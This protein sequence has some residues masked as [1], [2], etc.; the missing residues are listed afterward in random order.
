L[1]TIREEPKVNGLPARAVTDIGRSRA[2]PALVSVADFSLW[3]RSKEVLRGIDLEIPP[4][5]FV[6]VIG[7]SGSGKSTLLNAIAGFIVPTSA[8]VTISG[9]IKVGDSPP[10]AHARRCGVVFQEYA[11][12]PWRTARRNVEFSLEALDVPAAER[13]S[14]SLQYLRQVGLGA[15]ADLYPHQLSGGMKQRVA[16]ARALAY[17]PSVLLMDEPLGALDALTREKLM[18]LIDRVWR[19]TQTTVVY[20]THNVSEAVFL[21]DRVL[22]LKAQPGEVVLDLAIDLPRP[23]DPLSSGAVELERRLRDAI[24]ESDTDEESD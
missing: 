10:A 13:T 19:Q 21:A 23:R 1:A 3:F 14:R 7:P 15:A 6:A 20:I 5:Q 16:I 12:F 17:E 22:V 11:L 8:G 2:Q 24:P 4:G 18:G 9:A